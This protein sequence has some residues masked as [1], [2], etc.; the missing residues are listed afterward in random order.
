[1][2]ATKEDFKR[3]QREGNGCTCDFCS[4]RKDVN[5]NWCPRCAKV[6]MAPP[7]WWE[8]MDVC[9]ECDRQMEAERDPN[10][11]PLFTDEERAM[12]SGMIYKAGNPDYAEPR[13]AR[14]DS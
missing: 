9:D 5:D 10:A 14:G 13:I 1:M 4:G 8:D 6:K 12:L 3:V 11:A 7:K 2:I